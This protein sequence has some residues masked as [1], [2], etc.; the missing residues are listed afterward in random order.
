MERIARMYIADIWCVETIPPSIIKHHASFFQ[1]V[2]KIQADIY[3]NWGSVHTVNGDWLC[4]PIPPVLANE[5]RCLFGVRPL[6]LDP[7]WFLDDL[8]TYNQTQSDTDYVDY[9]VPQLKIGDFDLTWDGELVINGSPM[10][11]YFGRDTF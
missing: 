5:I 3:S 11:V 8:D 9:T 6:K 2:D 4:A 1:N 10:G 7:E